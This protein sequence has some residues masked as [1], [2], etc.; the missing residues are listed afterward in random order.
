MLDHVKLSEDSY[1]TNPRMQGMLTVI[2]EEL[3]MPF[4][5]TLEKLTGTLH[6]NSIPM[7]SLCSAILNQ[8][9]K[10]SISHCSPQSVK[11]NAPSWVMWDILKGWV[12]IHPVVM[13]N[14]A[15]NSPA[16]KILEKPASFEADFTKHPEA[17]PASRTIKL[18]RFQVNPEPNWGPKARAGKKSERKRKL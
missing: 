7:V 1:H 17:S 18:V 4:Y 5:W 6:C 14:I 10:V 16:R 2:G 3:D 13:Q 11:T 9:Y 15:E 12:K 8:G